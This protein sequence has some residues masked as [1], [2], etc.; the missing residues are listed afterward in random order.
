MSDSGRVVA[1]GTNY[2][3]YNIHMYTWSYAPSNFIFPLTPADDTLVTK[4]TTIHWAVDGED[5]VDWK[6][7]LYLSTNSSLPTVFAAN[8]TDRNYKAVNLTPGATYYWKVVIKDGSDTVISSTVSQFTVQAVASVTLETPFVNYTRY[9]TSADLLWKGSDGLQYLVYM[10]TSAGD[11]DAQSTTW[12]TSNTLTLSGLSVNTTY[13]WKVRA[14]DGAGFVESPVRSFEITGNSGLWTHSTSSTFPTS[15]AISDDGNYSVVGYKDGKVKL[16]GKNN[17]TPLWT[18]DT[19]SEIYSVDISSDGEYIVVGSKNDKAYLFRYNSSSYIWRYDIGN[20]VY[21][22]AIS[23]DGKYIA[24]GG[25]NDKLYLFEGTDGSPEWISDTLEGDVVAVSI[26]SDGEYIAAGTDSSSYGY[27]YLF[28]K[29]D[30]EPVWL[31]DSLGVVSSLEINRDGTHIALASEDYTVYYYSIS[32]STSIWKYET[33]NK[34]TAVSISKDGKFLVAG[35]QDKYVHYFN[36]SSSQPIWSALTGASISS[37]SMTPDGSSIAVASGDQLYFFNENS[38]MFI[39]RQDTIGDIQ[40]VSITSDSS[41]VLLGDKDSSG[42]GLTKLYGSPYLKKAYI[43]S[44]LGTIVKQYENVTFQGYADDSSNVTGYYW[45]SNIDGLLSTNLS[46]TTNSLSAGNHTIT[47]QSQ[48]SGYDTSTEEVGPQEDSSTQYIWRMDESSGTTVS[49]SSSSNFNANTHNSPSWV[50]CKHGNCLEFDGS[51]DYVRSSSSISSVPTEFT[52]E[53]WVYLD[54]DPS[55]QK[56]LYESG[57][58]LMHLYLQSNNKVQF[59]TYSGSYGYEY[60]YSTTALT[61]GV[62]YHIA[63]TFSASNDQLK[64]YINGTVEDTE[65]TNS[66]YTLYNYGCYESIG[67]YACWGSSSYFEGKIDEV[68]RTHSLKTNFASTNTVTIHRWSHPALVS[69][70][71]N[72]PPTITGT[73]ITPITSQQY[74]WMSDTSSQDSNSRVSVYTKGYWPFE[75]TAG[76]TTYDQTAYNHDMSLNSIVRT[77][78]GKFGRAV[79][80]EHDSDSYLRD[81]YVGRGEK[82]DEFTLEAWVKVESLSSPDKFIASGNSPVRFYLYLDSAGKVNFDFDKYN[83]GGSWSRVYLDSTGRIGINEWRHVAVTINATSGEAK[84][85]IDGN[86]DTTKSFT[87]GSEGLLHSQCCTFYIGT[88][89]DSR[90]Y[91]NFDGKIDEVRLTKKELSPSEF[92][93]GAL[94]SS[95]ATFSALASDSDGSIANYTWISDVDGAFGYN[96]YLSIN[97][98]TKLSAGY[99]NITVKA[100]DN[101]GYS[102]TSSATMIRIKTIPVVNITS[103]T[104]NAAPT[105]TSVSLTATATDNDGSIATYQWSSDLDG[106]ISTSKDFS[107]TSL[108]AGY[109]NITFRAKDVDGYWSYRAYEHV[110]ITALKVSPDFGVQGS[111]FYDFDFSYKREITL[112][113][114]TSIDNTTI[115]IVLDNSTFDYQYVDQTGKDIRFFDESL[116]TKFSYYIEEWNYNGTSKIWVRIPDSGTSNFYLVYGNDLVISESNGTNVFEFFDDFSDGSLDSTLWKGDTSKFTECNGYLYAG[117]SCGSSGRNGYRLLSN[118][119]WTG[120]YVMEVRVYIDYTNWGGFQA[121][122]W[123]ESTSNGLGVGFRYYEDYYS[124]WDDNGNEWNHDDPYADD[125]VTVTLF[126]PSAEGYGSVSY[127][128]EADNTYYNRSIYNSGISGEEIALGEWQCDCWQNYTYRA[129]WDYIHVRNYDSTTYTIQIG[130]HTSANVVNNNITFKTTVADTNNLISNY[131]WISSKDGYIGNTSSFVVPSSSLTL[132]NHTISVKF[133]DSSGSW[134][135]WSNFTYKVYK[136]PTV[137]SLEI[138]AW[139]DDQGDRVFFNGTGSDTDGTIIGYRWSSSIDGVIS[140]SASFNTTTLSPGN[141]TIYFHVKDNTTLW[142]S[143]SDRWLYINDQPIGTIVSVYPTLTYTNG[144]KGAEVD[145]DTRHMWRFNEGTGTSTSDDGSY[146]Y[147][148]YLNNG[149]SWVDGKQGKALNFDGNNDYVQS[150]SSTSSHGGEVS[151]EAWIYLDTDSSSQR[152]IIQ[153]GTSPVGLCVNSDEKLYLKAYFNDGYAY[154]TGSTELST[155]KWYHVAATI[156]ESNDLM[157]LYVDGVEDGSYSLGSDYDLYHWGWYTRI[158]SDC[159]WWSCY[160]FDGKIDE[161][162]I[163]TTVRT[164]FGEKDNITFNGSATDQSGYVAAYSWSS[165]IDGQ[166]ST[167]A[168]FTIHESNLSFGNHTI[169]FKAQDETGAWSVPK[170]TNVVVRSFPYAKITSVEPWYV[171][172]GTQVNFSATASAPDSAN[173]TAYLW[174]SSIDGNLNTNL[175][176]STTNLSYG[177]HTITFMAKNSRGE[178]SQPYFANDGVSFVLVNDIPV[179]SINDI[180]PNPATKGEGRAPPVDQYTLGYW[181]FRESTGTETIDES[182]QNNNATLKGSQFESGIWDSSVYLDGDEDYI[183]VTEGDS[184]SDLGENDFTIEAWIY[185]T[186]SMS[187]GTHSIIRN[188]GDYNLFVSNGYLKAEV[189]YDGTRYYAISTET[190]M[191]STDTWYHLAAVWNAGDEEWTLYVNGNS[192]NDNSGDSDE[193]LDDYNIWFGNSERN[194]DTGFKGNIDEVRISNTSRSSSSLLYY[195]TLQSTINFVGSG[196]DGDGTIEANQWKSSIEGSLSSSGNFSLSAANFTVEEHTV[197]YRVQDDDSVWS[198]WATTSLDVRSYPTAYILSIGPNSTSE[199]LSVTLKGN[200]SDP[201]SSETFVIYRWWS[202]IDGWLGDSRNVTHS[203]WS[204]GNHTI[205]LQVKDNQGYWSMP[206]SGE[207]FINDVPTS[208]IDSV[209][210]NPAYHNN[211]TYTS[212]TFNGTTIDADGSI[213]TYYWN[214]SFEGVL[215]ITS[216]F[217]LDVNNVRNGNHT[218]TFQGKD[219]Y[220][221]WS[222]KITY[223]LIVLENPNASIASVSSTF[224]NQ[225]ATLWLN[226]SSSD[227]DG[228]VSNYS[229]ISSIDGEIGNLEDIS[230]STLTPGNHTITFKVKDDDGLWS[231]NATTNVEINAKPIVELIANIPTT[232]YGFSGSTSVQEADA[233]TLGFWNLDE[234][235]GSQ[236]SDSSS[237]NKHGTL[238]NGP[239]WITGLYDNGLEFDGSD[240]YVELPEL[241]PGDVF[242]VVTVEAWIKLQSEIDSGDDWVVFGSGKD[243]IFKLAINDDEEPFV[244]VKSSSFGTKTVTSDESLVAGYWYHL[245]AI[246]DS[247]EDIIQI[248]LNHELVANDTINTNFVL[249]RFATQQN[250]IGSSAGGSEDYFDGIIDEVRVSKVS[251]N[252]TD[253]V[254]RS[255]ASYILAFASDSDDSIEEMEWKSSIDDLLSGSNWLML[256]ASDLQAGNHNITFRAKDPHGFW[257]NFVNFTLNVKMY[258]RASITSITPNSTDVGDTIGFNATS[259]DSDG[260]VVEY[261]WRSSKDGVLSTSENFTSSTLSAGYHRITYQVKDNEGLWSVVEVSEV[262]LNEVPMASIGSLSQHVAY[263][264]NLTHYNIKFYGNVSDNDGSITHYYWN[265]S[266]DG[267]LSTDGNFTHNI[268]TLSL[269]NHTITFQGRDNYTTWSPKVSSWLVVK[270]YPNATITSVSPRSTD[271][272]NSVSF[273]GS[274]SDEDGTITG[275]EWTS[276][277]DGLLSTNASFSTSDLSAGFHRIFFKVKDNDTLWSLP[278]SS[279]VFINDISV[280]SISSIE[281]QIVYRNN[282]TYYN[283]SF[284][285]NVSDNDGSI[286]H[287]YWNSSKDGVLSTDGNFTHN[288]NTLSLGNHTITFQGRDN[289][290]TWSPK[291]SSWLVVKAY[292]NATIT[293]ISPSSISEGSTVSFSGSGSDEDGTI[294]GYE[295]RSSKDGHLST[296]SSFTLSNLSTGYHTIY[297]KV[298]DNDTL[299]SIAKSSGVFVNDIPTASITSFGSNVVY[300]NNLTVTS[301]TLNGSGSDNDGSITHYYWNSSKNGV[302]STIGNFSLSL[303]TLSVGN[304]TISI[305]VRDNYTSWSTPVQSWLVVKAY[306][307][308]TITSASPSFTNES[309]AVNFT[310]SG[311][312]EDGTITDYEWHSSIDGLFGTLSN[313]TFETLSPGNHTIYFKVKDNDSLWSISDTTYVVVNGRPVVDIVATIPSIIFGYSGNNTL[314]ESDSDTL[315]YWHFDDGSGTRADDSSSNSNH[316]T[317]KMTADWGSGLFGGGVELDGDEDYVLI[318][319]MLGGS[320]VFSDVTLEAWVNL[321][322]SVSDGEKMVIFSGGQDGFVEIGVNDDQ[323]PYFK[324]K[325]GSFSWKT[326]TSN[327]T[328]EPGAWYH[329]SAVYSETDSYIKIYINRQLSGTNN[330]PDTFVLSRSLS[331]KNC[332]G[333]GTSGSSVC[334]INNLGGKIDEFRI[335]TSIRDVNNYISLYDTTYLS[336]TSY[337][338][339]NLITDIEWESSIDGIISYDPSLL[340]NA[341]TLS[342]GNHTITFRAKDNYGFWSHDAT[343]PL[344]VRHHPRS[345][346]NSISHYSTDENV[347][348]SFTGDASDTDGSVIA[349]EWHSSLDGVF[350][351]DK[352]TENNT[353]SVGYH[354]ISFKVKDD[355]GLWS[356]TNSASLFINDIPEANISSQSRYVT[357]QNNY[358]HFNVNFYGNISDSDG[359]ITHNYWNSSKDGVLSTSGNFTINV[360]SLSLGNHTITFQ[361]RDNYTTWSPKVTTWLVVKAYPNATISSQS[362]YSINYGDSVAFVGNGSDGDGYITDYEWMSSR[363][364]LISTESS[365]TNSSLSTGFHW[366]SFK[367]KDNDTLWSREVTVP[368]S[369]NDVPVSVIDDINPHVSYKNN[370]TNYNISFS[371]S[372]YD[373]DGQVTSFYWN[374]SKDGVLGTSGN[375]TINVNTLS[376]GNHTITFQGADNGTAWSPKTY[377]WI[378]VKAYPNATITYVSDTFSNETTNVEFRSDGS[379]EDG[380]ITDYRWYSSIDGLVSNLQNF[381]IS[382]LS[383]GEHLIELKVKDNDSLWS[384]SDSINLTV[385]GKPIVEI[386]GSVPSVIYEFSG[387][388]TIPLPNEDTLAF[389]SF[390][391]QEGTKAYDSTENDY[392]I[393][394]QNGPFFTSGL[395]ENAVE[396]DGDN[397]YLYVPSLVSGVSVFSEVTLEAWIYLENPVASGEKA[398][399]FSGGNDGT[400]DIGINSNQQI[401]FRANSNSIGWITVTTNETIADDRWYHV[402][403]VYSD[404]EDIVQ[405]YINHELVADYDL[406][407]TFELSFNSGFGNKIGS[408]LSGSNK[409]GGKIDEFRVTEGILTSDEFIRGHDLAYFVATSYDFEDSI[410]NVF[411]YSSL[412][413]FFTSGYWWQANSTTSEPFLSL[414]YHNISFRVQDNYGFWSDYALSSLFIKAHPQS[415]I[416]NVSSYSFNYGTPLYLEGNAI[417]KDGDEDSVVA[418][419]WI[420][421]IDGK[422]SDNISTSSIILSPGNHNVSFK[423][424]DVDGLWS[425]TDTVTI[426]VN[427]IPVAFIEGVSPNPAYKYNETEQIISFIGVATDNDGEIVDYYWNSSIYGVIGREHDTSI[428]ADNLSVGNH[429]ITYQVKD[430]FGTWSS[431]YTVNLIIYSNPIASIIDINPGFQAEDEPVKFEGMGSDED[432]LIIDYR[433]YSSIDGLF[434]TLQIFN[435]TDLSPGNH[436]ISFQVKDDSGLWSDFDMSYVVINSR[437]SVELIN[438]VPNLIYAFGPNQDLQLPDVYTVGYWHFDNNTGG[439][440]K[441]SSFNNPSND[442]TIQGNPV[443]VPGLF[444]NSLAFDGT[445][446]SV[447]TPELVKTGTKVFEEVTIE[448]WVYLDQN[449]VFDRD[450]VIFG[451]GQDGRLEI[452]ISVNHEAYVTVYSDTLGTY[453][454]F[455]E[456][457]INKLQWYHIA[458]VY[459]EQND[460]IKIYIN[461]EYDDSIIIPSQFELGRSALVNNCIGANSG[462][463]GRNFIGLIDEIRITSSLLYPEQFLYR[464]DRAYISAIV[465]DYD[466][467]ITGGIWESDINGVLGTDL[468]LSKLATDLMPGLH[469]LTFRAVDEYGVWSLNATTQLYIS[470]YPVVEELLIETAYDY[471]VNQELVYFNGTVG[472]YDGGNIVNYQWFSSIDGNLGD[473]LNVIARLSNGTHE[474]RFRAQDDEG[475]WSAWNY[476]TYFVDAHPIAGGYSGTYEIYRGE[477][478]PITIE[479]GNFNNNNLTDEDIALLSSYQ[480]ELQINYTD[481][482]RNSELDNWS[483]QFLVQPIFNNSNLW[484]GYLS[485]SMEMETG[486]YQI[487]SRTIQDGSRIT[488]WISLFNITISNNP[489]IINEVSFSNSTLQRNQEAT[490]SLDIDDI[491]LAD[492]VSNLEVAVSYFDKDEDEWITGF[493]SEAYLNETTGK[494]DVDVLPPPDLKP[495]KYDLRL[496]VTDPDGEIVTVTQDNA[497]T[498]VNSKPVVEELLTEVDDYYNH[499][500]SSFWLNVT[501]QDVDGEIFGYQWRSNI[502]GTLPC[503]TD[504]C[505]LDPAT[506]APGTHQITVYAEDED[507]ELSEE[508]LTFEVTIRDPVA[509]AAADATALDS[510]IAGDF[511]VLI[512]A[513]LVAFILIAGTLRLRNREEVFVEE[514]FEDVLPR[515]PVAAWLPPLEMNSHEEV[516]AEFFIKRRESYLAYPSNEEILDFLHN[517]RERYAISSYF[518]VPTS[519]SE[520]LQE[521]ALPPNLRYNVHLDDVRKSIVNT[522]LDDTTGKNFVIFGEPGV[523]KSV[524]GFDVFDRL[525]DRMPVGRI[526]TSSVGNVHEK[527]GIR[528]F[529]DD[530]PENSELIQVMQ[531]RKIKGL[532]VTAREADWRSLPKEFQDMF[533]RLTVPLFPEEEMHNLASR[534]LGFSGLM[535]EPQA[536]DKLAVFSEGSPIYVWSLIRELIHQDIKKLTLTYLNENSMKGMTNYVS[537][538]LQQLLKEGGEYKSGG[539]HTLAAV[540]FLSTYMAEKTS[541]EI[542]FRAFAE[543][544]S[545]KTKTVF[546]DEMDTMTFNHAMGYLSGEGSQVRFPHD[547]WADVL[548]GEGSMN[549][550]RAE[551]QTIVQEFSD[552]GLFEE[553]K[554]EAVPNAWETAVSR[555]EKSPSRQH[556]AL[557]SLADTLFRNFGVKDLKK[558]GVDS[559]FVLEVATTYSHLPIA[560][561]LVSKIQAARPQQ[562]TKIINIQDSVSEQQSFGDSSSHPPYTM[563]ELYL[564]YNDGRLIASE[565][566]REAKVDSDIMSSM[567]TA[568]N[569]FVKDSFQTEGNL[570]A[571]DYGEN[572]IILERGENTVMAAVVYG[573]ATRDLRSKMGGAVIDLEEQFGEDLAAWD[574]DIDKLA[575]TK[576]ILAPIIGMT[577]GVTRDMIEDYLS[578]Q[579]VRM[580]SSS[581]DYKGFL[582]AKAHINNYSSTTIKDVIL[583][584]DY[585]KSKIKLVQ[586]NPKFKFDNFKVNIEEIRG[587]KDLEVSLYF[588][589]LEKKNIGLNLRLDYT[590]PRGEGSQVSSTACEGITFKSSVKEPNMDDL[591][592]EVEEESKP[593]PVEVPSVVEE[594]APVETVGDGVEVLES[595][596]E[597][598]DVDIEEAPAFETVEDEPEEE[599]EETVEEEPE[600]E[601]EQEPVDLGE[602]GMDDLLGKLGELGDD[603]V[604]KAKPEEEEKPED[605]KGMDDLLGKLDEL[606][607]DSK[608][609]AKP[610]KGK[611]SKSKKSKK[612]KESKEEKS[613]DDEEMD[614]LLSKLDEL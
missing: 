162:R 161:V 249:Q 539:Y 27:L 50:E 591:E 555:Y 220:G 45:T 429:T 609:E 97:V 556:E 505:E 490:L 371:G 559:D 494:F 26:S 422:I 389:W 398:T 338:F 587:Y 14:F 445:V 449:Y 261:K 584:L 581:D 480:V 476:S 223:Y 256:K 313:F 543:Q 159:G 245:A 478:I 363:D 461:G 181:P 444:N 458:V 603:D 413:G 77:G 462:C 102:V 548:E 527:F 325:S 521:W 438:S 182:G 100:T 613:S 183:Y 144:T 229:W 569:D 551:I 351:T 566:S 479:I 254:S 575:G 70:R 331:A 31:D 37:L 522:I 332:I 602:S 12:K 529:Y 36:T 107:L 7:D 1:A 110:L 6:Y 21:S 51:N 129:W 390:N 576:E 185:P 151:L 106:I 250:S 457:Q 115:E 380:Y 574:G 385:N 437:P 404:Q 466:S 545:D 52:V 25:K 33:G 199:G 414:G 111:G 277:K 528:L 179:A 538:L 242:D 19:E 88:S 135:G 173:L 406:Q 293:S 109:H 541:H 606:D 150:S 496:E 417:D 456:N 525:M 206:V 176:F 597:V 225:Y 594:S 44:T 346:I 365:F 384:L 394:L 342:A 430:S 128:N 257:S 15:V 415:S 572:K 377:S 95:N 271:E 168:N 53:M 138:S 48:Y 260:N 517:N 599:S 432:G 329:V 269:G 530:L 237:S 41:Y 231:T 420:S 316:G 534:M 287:Y 227:N 314:P 133:K 40:D 507:G 164:E 99:H 612:S 38:L 355:D 96:S 453:Q 367:V 433:W 472:D 302:L 501:G 358:T 124:G 582:E 42:D 16:F 177:N 71:V 221:A 364:G 309:D 90:D 383:P 465:V 537:L 315:G 285:G 20:Y 204:P 532:V 295:W 488:P 459:S 174:T 212:V 207:L 202:S 471:P 34:A 78:S 248:Y 272:G 243:G 112:S 359:S 157:K 81:Y 116:N 171:N 247:E 440:V 426:F 366:I 296:S 93:L 513:G 226:G 213:T 274:G 2:E 156:S 291:V 13:Y 511:N 222:P 74:G 298:K 452:G 423:V 241:I 512:I 215:G 585:N 244:Y 483:T 550:F 196:S 235:S 300:K 105:G 428:S 54:S 8:L 163:S 94:S 39:W 350:S 412:D 327:K 469:N 486:L 47:L 402:A 552:S 64:I 152:C 558:L 83:I 391:E 23:S 544:L 463:S 67:G 450:R 230:I 524:I 246:Y 405:I 131:T 180:S 448:A 130:N 607:S 76:S 98:T 580:K 369:V 137:S 474:I 403:F 345:S 205:F 218:I 564:V 283:S 284:Y 252:T 120:S 374:S 89:I 393:T 65:S 160:Y 292:P 549:P 396:L 546:D 516:L 200:A 487:R 263:K 491:E 399:I 91:Y 520:L 323:Y 562:V 79:D 518:E 446:D 320:S 523:G 68:H 60:A 10:G 149:P 500:N 18:H 62:W 46:F 605:K 264:N 586:V 499:G 356:I 540:N 303:D 336:A 169:T 49:D 485:P 307:N 330:L 217:V 59:R 588:E 194:S 127:Y 87:V 209:T 259:S 273:S 192:Q 464:S 101:E 211:A 339:E 425:I 56:V 255:D 268:N 228:S 104:P 203:D 373:K 333:A 419:E 153:W 441:D 561:T 526:T 395:F 362:S 352:N 368:F 334:A 408:S 184:I 519:P 321:D 593:K 318:P 214:S 409:F 28:D 557:L 147:T 297:F 498:I 589:V 280:A 132:G 3:P 361:G 326:V 143:K 69:L 125:W 348:I 611:K 85:F 154:L 565:H 186:R 590:N 86:L 172:I 282:L 439:K 5:A 427:D 434:G 353:L 554:R 567:L 317:L 299:W 400:L 82:W 288:I 583:G 35:S 270:A 123:H 304:H 397:D 103:I 290:T 72:G 232:V 376:L 175:S 435:I 431:N 328:I 418:F 596:V 281:P 305:Q 9:V 262:F 224:V 286:T 17:N 542:F 266:K 595:D 114:A 514:E 208:S 492:N 598:M 347:L 136:T 360:N 308:A 240:D 189:W 278:Q 289:Y 509:E 11:L 601:E 145:S 535:Y 401:Y 382:T 386:V 165:S 436:T 324:A 379:D 563:E 579:E 121:A 236:A 592:F 210:P 443:L 24:V 119:E 560:A 503:A 502:Q 335:S 267:V 508:P 126:G 614:D 73:T 343:T 504:K 571:I 349:Y 310:G 238:K 451:G 148:G 495:G 233:N 411:W 604:P 265:S 258:P 312:D 195:T 475:H 515:D 460:E 354:T 467:Q 239:S 375:F 455:S 454:L 484:V 276:G 510:L 442:L 134:S 357:Y 311:S 75:E 188:D 482:A 381:N 167:Q 322:S 43:N 187:S 178:W 279:N 536:L 118:E 219:N 66:A 447:A 570:G 568:I 30:S 468:W 122:G 4:N 117:E 166:L 198:P 201:D 55:S 234:T 80:L 337:D 497:F 142:S 531:E 139:M 470:T 489:P 108:S 84:I 340:I 306:P 600:E 57:R 141:H 344:T 319:D 410:S 22:V 92:I 421:D 29:D 573:E 191:S 610:N 407:T 416:S 387:N 253:M 577:E 477:T 301:V 190:Q 341:T 251:R 294:T 140:T 275:Y 481:S 473:E 216:D 424:K 493:F 370:L 63:A 578:M 392:D 197:S 113:S 553:V 61:T 58:G 372:S 388:N 547:T 155:N 32:S 608:P 506:L 170:T 533:E 158:G 146:G 378:V 193:T